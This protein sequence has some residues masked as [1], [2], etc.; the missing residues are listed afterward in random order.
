LDAELF[1]NRKSE[2]NGKETITY[3]RL[4]KR[5]GLSIFQAPD[6]IS[7]LISSA[8]IHDTFRVVH[9]TVAYEPIKKRVGIEVTQNG[10]CDYDLELTLPLRDIDIIGGNCQSDTDGTLVE[11]EIDPE[12][13]DSCEI[14]DDWEP[15]G[16]A[17]CLKF[18]Q[19]PP[20]IDPPITPV[21]T[22]PVGTGCPPQGFVISSNTQTADCTN[23]W[24]FEGAKYK[25]KITKEIADGECG[26]SVQVSYAE[27]CTG[28]GTHTVS[29]LQCSGGVINPTPPVGTPPV[30]TP[31]VGTPP[32]GTPPVGT[33][34][35]G[36]PPVGTYPAQ[37]EFIMGTTGYG[38]DA[39][40]PHG[41]AP[42]WVEKI[43]AFNY[44]WG[45]GIT[46][47]DLWVT[48]D[49]YEETPGAYE[50]AALQRVINFCSARGLGLSLV[51]I[52]RR[53]EMDGFLNVG[54]RVTLHTGE[55][56]KDGFDVYP[57]YGCD[58]TN[59]LIYNAIQSMTN[60]LKTYNRVLS[61]CCAGGHAGELNNHIKNMGGPSVGLADFC[62][63]N[64]SRFNA[65]CTSRG[66]ATPGTP[67]V[68]VPE[69]YF[70]PYPDFHDARGLE[71]ARFTT[72]NIYKY[73]KNFCNAVK[74]VAPNIP[75]IYMYAAAAASVQFR[76]TANAP[77][78]F[79]ASPGNGMY[80]SDGDGLYDAK[81]KILVNAV[82]RGNFPNGL[83]FC[84]FDPNDTSTYTYD[85]GTAPP[86][87]Q[88]NPQWGQVKTYM[89]QLYQ[90]GIRGIKTA[91][92]FSTGE[93]AAASGALQQL[94][95]TWIGKPY[96]P[97]VVNTENTTTVEVTNKYRNGEDLAE[98]IDPYTRFIKYTSNDYWGGVNPPA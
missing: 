14:E 4:T 59:T 51:F 33:P 57:S 23:A 96:N 16:E 5:K 36:T 18:G 10:C 35:V 68:I 75:C 53:N 63:D 56:F 6:F 52:A 67:P 45:W 15:T 74:S 19:V 86:F 88:A 30:G 84:E 79:I 81:M 34:P 54:E 25:K 28:I 80:G 92:A 22:P 3:Q 21:G 31:P 32:V 91:M 69:N 20:D 66:L 24:V 76:S 77:M 94:R 8:K 97:P 17:L 26:T 48:W 49:R 11:I 65:W 37:Y 61:F 98:G 43:E 89:E 38:F 13:P 50:T 39:T 87:G 83:S 42:E 73:Y 1:E 46:A 70:W 82:N 93:I 9:Q 90:R 72:Y 7:E 27:P 41:I 71:F 40:Q 44:P 2:N 47:I 62:S 12:L 85:T 60:V 55:V 64:L 58:R 29:N 95:Q 78:N